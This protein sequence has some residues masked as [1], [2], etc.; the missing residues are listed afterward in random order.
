MN[1]ALFFFMWKKKRSGEKRVK[2]LKKVRSRNG[3]SWKKKKKERDGGWR[4]QRKIIGSLDK[5]IGGAFLLCKKKKKKG[6]VHWYSCLLLCSAVD[7]FLFLFIGTR[8]ESFIIVIIDHKTIS[9]S[10]KI[11][12][13]YYYLNCP[14]GRK[15]RKEN[16]GKV[17]I[18]IHVYQRIIKLTIAFLPCTFVFLITHN[19]IRV[20]RGRTTG[21]KRGTYLMRLIFNRAWV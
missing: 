17:Y 1:D 21:R 8:I 12:L 5:E 4:E 18:Y 13:F 20:S 11:H 2:K 9:F 10:G 14:L 3:R 19:V 15:G 16:E 7:L 6:G